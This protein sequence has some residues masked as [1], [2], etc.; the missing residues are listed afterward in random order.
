MN[1]LIHK[2]HIKSHDLFVGNNIETRCNNYRFWWFTR[3]GARTNKVS[4]N[5]KMDSKIHPRRHK[6]TMA[7]LWSTNQAKSAQI[8]RKQ[9]NTT[10]YNGFGGEVI[11]HASRPEGPANLLIQL[12]SRSKQKYFRYFWPACVGYLQIMFVCRDCLRLH[13]KTLFPS[14]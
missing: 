2:N 5:I 10:K 13:R 12:L 9:K 4:N 1:I 11:K 6:K 14:C 3:L 8:V 7:F